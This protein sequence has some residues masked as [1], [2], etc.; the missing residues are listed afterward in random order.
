L[1]EGGLQFSTDE[2]PEGGQEKL[3]QH[4]RNEESYQGEQGRFAQELPDELHPVSS[5]DLPHPD[6]SRP[7]GRSGCG[8]IHIVKAGNEQDKEADGRKKID[9]ADIRS[10]LKLKIGLGGEV[11]VT[12]G[13]KAEG[14]GGIVAVIS[15]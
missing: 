9:V 15:L 5:D 3:D 7:G 4:D 8:Q 12:H 6:L 2:N 13:L 1:D 14:L 11:D 10:R